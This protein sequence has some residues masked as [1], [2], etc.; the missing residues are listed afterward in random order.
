[1]TPREWEIV[2]M[3]AAGNINAELGA[4]RAGAHLSCRLLTMELV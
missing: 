3:V 4:A 2:H 1:L